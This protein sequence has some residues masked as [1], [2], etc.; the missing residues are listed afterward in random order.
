[1]AGV[2]GGG[3]RAGREPAAQ[4]QT[5]KKK[6]VVAFCKEQTHRQASKMVEERDLDA[7]VLLD[8]RRHKILLARK[9][10]LE[11]RTFLPPPWAGCRLLFKLL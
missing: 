3:G 4:G 9:T 1:M 10:G 7:R 2:L 5:T 11:G 8:P 6:Q